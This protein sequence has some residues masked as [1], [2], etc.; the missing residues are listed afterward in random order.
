ML[1]VGVVQRPHGLRGEVSVDPTTDFPE[2]FQPGTTLLWRRAA[3]E[4]PLTV[5]TARRHGSRILLRFEGIV[6]PVGARALAGGELCVDSALATPA[7]TDFYYSHEIEG[8]S[9][10]D[11]REGAL[12]KAARLEET[13]AGPLLAIK[14][15]AGKEALVPFVRPYVVEVD[16]VSRRIVLDLPEGLM[17]IG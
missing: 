11:V 14:T 8:F 7:P 5:E 3:E 6:D 12:G 13:A 4:R 16:R 10:E 15:P 9:C 2:R 1:L 17:E